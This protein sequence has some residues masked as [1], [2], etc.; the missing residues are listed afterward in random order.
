ML[1][2]SN[3][4]PVFILV[5]KDSGPGVSLAITGIPLDHASITTLPSGSTRDG[6]SHMSAAPAKRKTLSAQGKM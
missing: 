2:T 5:I 3:K 1:L 4:T 6:T